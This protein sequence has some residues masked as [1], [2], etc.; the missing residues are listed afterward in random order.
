MRFR[1][2][3][4]RARAQK[5]QRPTSIMRGPWPI[6]SSGTICPSHRYVHVIGGVLGTV[7]SPA[8][9]QQQS[10]NSQ[11]DSNPCY[12]RER[13]VTAFSAELSEGLHRCR[14]SSRRLAQSDSRRPTPAA[15]AAI[16]IF[17]RAGTR[18]ASYALEEFLQG[19]GRTV[20]SDLTAA[21]LYGVT[22]TEQG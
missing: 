2:I 5:Q 19:L 18:P 13:E 22:S 12:R 3:G 6:P 1:C 10:A 20:R 21:L 16:A 15:R 8:L 4:G 11:G 14:R 9:S 17:L 7:G